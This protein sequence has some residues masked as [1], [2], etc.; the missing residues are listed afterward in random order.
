MTTEPQ[1]YLEETG[2]LYRLGGLSTTLLRRQCGD[3]VFQIQGAV[4]DARQV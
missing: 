4:G 2:R 1:K 3:A